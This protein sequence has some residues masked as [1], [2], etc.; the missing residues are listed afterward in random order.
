MGQRVLVT[1]DSLSDKQGKELK[2]WWA[3]NGKQFVEGGGRRIVRPLGNRFIN[4]E[5]KEI[6]EGRTIVVSNGEM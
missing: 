6:P 2:E 3:E 5:L 4:F 1:P